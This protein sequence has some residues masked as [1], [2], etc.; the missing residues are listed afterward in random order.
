MK[1][2]FLFSTLSLL[3]FAIYV[4]FLS[5]STLLLVNDTPF[6]LS[7]RVESQSGI[8]L[9]TYDMQPYEQKN[10]VIDTSEF[11]AG[12][13]GN[14]GYLLTPYTVIWMC[15]SKGQYGIE[16]NVSP[17]ASVKATLSNGKHYCEPPEEEEE[18]KEN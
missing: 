6:E 11:S 3:S 7:A 17:G 8:I 4:A 16:T 15:K 14:R 10:V 1:R 5:E 9:G 2:L 12:N 18:E 13:I